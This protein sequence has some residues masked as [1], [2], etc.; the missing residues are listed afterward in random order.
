MIFGYVSS[1]LCSVRT[2]L[3][4]NMILS[5]QF[6]AALGISLAIF[7]Y[8]KEGGQPQGAYLNKVINV[9]FNKRAV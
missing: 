9:F 8:T 2:G 4:S 6:Q 1:I 3:Q 7:R 5:L